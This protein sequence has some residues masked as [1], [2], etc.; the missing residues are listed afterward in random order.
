M[1]KTQKLIRNSRKV[2]KAVETISK[3]KDFKKFM[4][5]KYIAKIKMSSPK[6]C[7]IELNDKPSSKNIKDIEKMAK[8]FG[9]DITWDTDYP[10][11]LTVK[12]K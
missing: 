5:K 8:K 11:V 3:L 9:V 4:E 12:G 6:I 2:I 1:N 7:N 10:E